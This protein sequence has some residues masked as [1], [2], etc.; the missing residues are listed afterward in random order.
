MP[1]TQRS[2][3]KFRPNENQ[4]NI[5]ITNQ[6]QIEEATNSAFNSAR[7]SLK[8][9]GNPNFDKITFKNINQACNTT[10]VSPKSTRDNFIRI[11]KNQKPP[12][13][14]HSQKDLYQSVFN[15]KN[16]LFTT[17]D[18]N[19]QFNEIQGEESLS[20]LKNNTI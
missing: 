5:Q 14:Q 10:N 4:D 7:V 8:Q 9:N 6:R 12:R 16:C 20:T 13:Q 11:K 3:I 1:T 15:P 17:V 19:H 18:I 2:R